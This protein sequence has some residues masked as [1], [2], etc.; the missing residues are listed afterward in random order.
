MYV[1][2][3]LIHHIDQPFPIILLDILGTYTVAVL[4]AS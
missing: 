3:C 1:I 4:P 2:I